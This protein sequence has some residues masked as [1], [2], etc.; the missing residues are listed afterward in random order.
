MIIR[1]LFNLAAK[2]TLCY[3]LLLNDIGKKY[4]DQMFCY[5]DKPQFLIIRSGDVFP[6]G[7]FSDVLKTWGIL[8]KCN[9]KINVS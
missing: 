4:D 5:N 8:A 3:I 2:Y 9:Y 6:S 1:T 7:M